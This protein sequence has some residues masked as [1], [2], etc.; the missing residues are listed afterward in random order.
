MRFKAFRDVFLKSIVGLER[1]FD[2]FS[3][4]DFSTQT[5]ISGGNGR[6]DMI[7]SNS[8]YLIYVEVKISNTPRTKNQPLGYLRS[9][10]AEEDDAE[11]IFIFLCPKDYA[12]IKGCQADMVTFTSANKGQNITTRISHW[13]EFIESIQTQELN[14]L[15][16][17]IK[18]YHNLV[19]EWFIPNNTIFSTQ[20]LEIMYSS[21]IPRTLIKLIEF[22]Y[23]L[24]NQLK[25]EFIVK[26]DTPKYFQEHGFFLQNSKGNNIL[27]VGIWLELWEK[28]GAPIIIGLEDID[29]K[30]SLIRFKE[31]C[32]KKGLLPQ[33]FNE[34]NYDYTWIG[35]DRKYIDT[36]DKESLKTL[37]S[38]FKPL[39]Q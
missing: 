7:I 15:N 17:I 18:E 38:N 9:L 8:D 37:I 14:D 22:I 16:P 36:N 12:D 39:L 29:N 24:K 27:F 26:D 25:D 3:F 13:F 20:N 35:V 23:E 1:G 11:K 31:I 2:K 32:N 4:S 30:N 19:D 10:I 5:G 34:E 33:R 6:P 21:E 28:K